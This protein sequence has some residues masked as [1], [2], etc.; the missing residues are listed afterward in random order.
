MIR[1]TLSKPLSAVLAVLTLHA[2]LAARADDLP[3]GGRQ[4]EEL[5]QEENTWLLGDWRGWR[6]RLLED[7]ID[8]QL[9]YTGEFAFNLLRR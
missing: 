2:P 6:S 4:A 7:G 1:S 8:F 3:L 9:G 5:S